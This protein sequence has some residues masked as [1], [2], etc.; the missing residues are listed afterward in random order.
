[1]SIFYRV[2]LYSKAGS[3]LSKLSGVISICCRSAET[4]TGSGSV[5]VNLGVMVFDQTNS[6]DY[7]NSSW[8]T[9]GIGPASMLETKTEILVGSLMICSAL[10]QSLVMTRTG[11]PS[12]FSQ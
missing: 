1:M 2:K 8:G 12:H 11:D 7:E 3:L 6:F 10:I 4:S 9:A 5:I